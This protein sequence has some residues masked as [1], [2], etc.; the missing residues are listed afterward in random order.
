MIANICLVIT[1]LIASLVDI[2]RRIVPAYIYVA[3]TAIGIPS[4]GWDSF[5]G[6]IFGLL[7]TLIPAL[8]KSGIGGGDI[9]IC[10]FCGFVMGLYILPALILGLSLAIVSVPI[11]KRI[12]ND[13]DSSF[14]L[15]PWI[16]LGCIAITVL[17]VVVTI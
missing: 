1:L 17:Q 5:Y 13:K 16:S 3:L 10:A 11:I 2:K 14:A 9:K 6:F 7:C 4:F 12:R 15:V 8:I